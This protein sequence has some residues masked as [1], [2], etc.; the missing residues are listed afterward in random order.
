MSHVA[1]V[2]DAPKF[3]SRKTKADLEGM[4]EQDQVRV[5]VCVV[6]CVFFGGGGGVCCRV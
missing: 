5:R 6:V 4:T 1:H 3:S 2:T